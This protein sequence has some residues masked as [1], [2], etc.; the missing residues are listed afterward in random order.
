VEG[1]L[2]VW[3]KA[4]KMPIGNVL[5]ILGTLCE[6]TA[7]GVLIWGN[8]SVPIWGKWFFLVCAL[9]S[10]NFAGFGIF[11]WLLARIMDNEAKGIE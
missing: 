1:G 4:E 9:I 3:L 6:I 7:I 5:R 11:L 10:L 2:F 8:I